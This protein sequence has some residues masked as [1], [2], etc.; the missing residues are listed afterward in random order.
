MRARES[1]LKMIWKLSVVTVIFI[2]SLLV[3]KLVFY[4]EPLD[5]PHI[6]MATEYIPTENDIDCSYIQD[7][8]RTR[9]ELSL[10]LNN[11]R[12]IIGQMQCEVIIN[13]LNQ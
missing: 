6:S 5:N 4:K 10:K 8:I 12:R 1:N 7:I 11:V 3:S 13:Y 9:N 2:F